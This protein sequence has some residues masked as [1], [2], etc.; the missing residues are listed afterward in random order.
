MILYSSIP[1]DDI[2]DAFAHSNACVNNFPT[3]ANP[4]HATPNEMWYGVRLEMSKRLCRGIF[5]CLVYDHVDADKRLKNEDRARPGIYL[6]W[7]ET[8]G[9][10]FI[11]DWMSGRKGF[12]RDLKFVPSVMPHR[13][14]PD[15]LMRYQRLMGRPSIGD[16][17]MD[18]DAVR[19][20]HTPYTWIV[21]ICQGPGEPRACELQSWRFGRLQCARVS[22]RPQRPW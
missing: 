16:H 21:P 20:R 14:R 9:A 12:T 2:P 13:D 4:N 15:F 8:H 5:G 22:H 17:P 6:G 10:F 11:K 1:D 3:S 19:A 7:E 18:I